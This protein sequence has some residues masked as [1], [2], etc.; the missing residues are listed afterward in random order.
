MR[1]ETGARF[2]DWGLNLPDVNYGPSFPANYRPG[3]GVIGCGAIPQSSHLKAYAKSAVNVKGVYDV[4]PEAARAA[5]STTDLPK[6]YQTL[7]ELLS[8]RGVTVVDIATTPDMRVP[9][10]MSAM[11]AWRADPGLEATREHHRRGSW[12]CG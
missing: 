7:D 11:K 10:M 3:V 6:V 9:L 8:D 4:R 1:W 12:G 5:Y 2:Y